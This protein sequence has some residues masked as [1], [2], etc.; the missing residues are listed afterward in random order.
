[1]GG[2]GNGG[3]R[4]AKAGVK[5][6]EKQDGVQSWS[7]KSMSCPGE[8]EWGLRSR[9]VGKVGRNAKVEGRRLRS[10]NEGELRMRSNGKRERWIG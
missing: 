2:E 3:G 4:D 8:R 5:E 1:M 6:E 7:E 10:K 9:D